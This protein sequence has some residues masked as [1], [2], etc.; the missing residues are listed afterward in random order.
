MV[1]KHSLPIKQSNFS[2]TLPV[3]DLIRIWTSRL[4]TTSTIELLFRRIVS[5]ADTFHSR[6]AM[7]VA[8]AEWS[9]LALSAALTRV[10]TGGPPEILDALRI[11][12]TFDVFDPGDAGEWIVDF[13]ELG[14][15][16]ASFEAVVVDVGGGPEFDVG[17]SAHC[18]GG[19]VGI[20]GGCCWC[21]DEDLID[22]LRC[23]WY[24]LYLLS[25]PRGD[26]CYRTRM[27]W[28][29]NEFVDRAP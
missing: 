25:Y 23:R 17:F 3:H 14:L 12:V 6:L 27:K 1:L 5:I 11:A 10:S 7:V 28:K 20:L 8:A 13:C 29:E 2:P 18:C 4:E 26:L 24:V 16:D 21:F 19:L 9:D 22:A 15:F